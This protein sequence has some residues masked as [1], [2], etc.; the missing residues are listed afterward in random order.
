M[1]ANS[2]PEANVDA[3]LLTLLG[4]ITTRS[5]GHGQS[6]LG[7]HILKTASKL[8]DFHA[9][10]TLLVRALG[11]NGSLDD[12]SLI[13]PFQHLKRAAELGENAEAMN[14]YGMAFERKG[15]IESAFQWYVKAGNANYSTPETTRNMLGVSDALVS[16]GKFWCQR[17]EF[18]K[19]R[20][21]FKKAAIE[22]DNPTAY[23]YLG[24][25]MKSASTQQEIYR[26][27]KS[28]EKQF[29]FALIHE[30]RAWFIRRIRNNC[31]RNMIYP[32]NISSSS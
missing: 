13:E 10:N 18:D 4:L 3:R 32:K 2:I 6:R 17:K 24:L 9:T 11:P 23:Y 29:S 30:L 14:L 16:L 7:H 19:A 21:A 26:K 15:Q 5:P 12:P 28:P 27:S 8:G 31:S 22:L 25:L 1:N 20:I